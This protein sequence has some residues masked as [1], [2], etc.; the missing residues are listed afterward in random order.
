M[1]AK[2]ITISNQKGGV[3]KTTTAVNLAHCLTLKNKQV[4][5][6]DLDPQGQCATQLGM[7]GQMGAYYF[8][9]TLPTSPSEVTFIRQWIKETHRDNLRLIPGNSMTASAQIILSDQEQPISYIRGLLKTFTRDRFDYIIFDT[10]S[11]EDGLQMRAIWAAD[12]VIIPTATEF[13]SLDSIAKMVIPL[14]ILR[15][16]KNWHG[17]VLGILPT[18]YDSTRESR[19]AL[20]DLQNAF[21][22]KV[23]SPIHRATVLRECWSEGKTIFEYAPESRSAREYQLLAKLVRKY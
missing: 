15:D 8:L 11:S 5:L 10:S 13:A 16:E 17:G 22:D 6:I 21:K 14:Q 3:G 7:G 23:L 20:I 2:V 18:F 9:T 19:H 1:T 4:L 12:L